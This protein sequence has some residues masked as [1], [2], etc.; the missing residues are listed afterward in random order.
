[1]PKRRPL[2]E[3]LLAKVELIPF[4]TCWWFTGALNP[5]GYGNITRGAGYHESLKAHRVS[6][7]VHNGPIPEKSHVCHTCDEPSCVNPAHLFLS[8]HKGNMEDKARKNRSHKK[9]NWA[10][11]HAIRYLG[12]V[13]VRVGVLS[14]QFNTSHSLISMIL[15]RKRW[16]EIPEKT[17]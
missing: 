4:S 3:R 13:G 12:A 5:D 7:E 6:W 17:T 2:K 16:L 15:N 9:L 10:K 1:M 14:K 11:V 8:D